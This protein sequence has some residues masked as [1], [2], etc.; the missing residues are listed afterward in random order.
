MKYGKKLSKTFV[1]KYRYPREEASTGK[2]W[3]PGSGPVHSAFLVAVSRAAAR[4]EMCGSE[5]FRQEQRR[6]LG[7]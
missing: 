3:P 6:C 1:L 5:A 4:L 2:T 7:V